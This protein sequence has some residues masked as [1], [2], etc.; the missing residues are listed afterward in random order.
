MGV[1]VVKLQSP[2]RCRRQTDIIEL[3]R[4]LAFLVAE[5]EHTHSIIASAERLYKREHVLGIV[6]LPV[7]T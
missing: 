5:I 7:S 2:A 3:E 6:P 1:A 4:H